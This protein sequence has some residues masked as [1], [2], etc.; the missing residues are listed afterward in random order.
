[1]AFLS[2][3][4][5]YSDLPS[6]LDFPLYDPLSE[7]LQPPVPTPSLSSQLPLSKQGRHLGSI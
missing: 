3:L 2:N 6:P 5:T 1:M 7:L 4:F